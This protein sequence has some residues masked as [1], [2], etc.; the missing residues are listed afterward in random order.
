M[1][2][3]VQYQTVVK[4]VDG[5]YGKSVDMIYVVAMDEDGVLWIKNSS[6]S[7]WLRF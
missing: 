5:A 4:K 2:K 6:D 1:K 7:K 3:I